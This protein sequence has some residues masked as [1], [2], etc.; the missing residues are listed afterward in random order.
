MIQ[1]L[2]IMIEQRWDSRNDWKYMIDKKIKQ[3]TEQANE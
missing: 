3:M 2:K 1:Q